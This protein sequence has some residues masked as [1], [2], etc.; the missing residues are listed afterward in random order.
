[1]RYIQPLPVEEL[2]PYADQIAGL[3][4]NALDH[5][6]DLLGSGWVQVK[7]GMSCRGLEGFR[8]ESGSPVVADQDGEWL[9]GRINRANEA[10][11]R[12][13]WQLIGPGYRPIDWQIDFKSGYRWS[14]AC[15]YL[16]IPYGHLPGVDIKV[17]WELAR[18]QHLPQLAWAYGLASAGEPGFGAP[19]VYAREFRSQVLDFIA[20]NPPRFGVN[21]AGAMDAA[22]RVTNW[23]ITY[24]LFRAYGAVFDEAFERELTRS[25]I[26]H[27][28]HLLSN[29]DWHAAWRGNHYLAEMAG[30]FVV[31]MYLSPEKRKNNFTAESAEKRN[32][33]TRNTKARHDAER[34]LALARRELDRETALQFHADGSNFEASTSYHRLAAEM[35]VYTAALALNLPPGKFPLGHSMRIEKMGEF[36]QHITKPSG[37]VPQ[38]GDND[39]GRFLKLFP[40]YER[41]TTE[42]ACARYAN[43]DGYESDEP[44]YWDEDVLDHRHLLAALNGLFGRDDWPTGPETLIVRGLAGGRQ[45]PSYRTDGALSAA[46]R[47]RIGGSWAD[48]QE[49]VRGLPYSH[50]CEDSCRG[51]ACCAQ[52]PLRL[53]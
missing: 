49:R 46:E 9:N 39:S 17:P 20:T 28:K 1:M 47:V 33:K 12:R 19:E 36:T 24:D 35:I 43:L 4:Q 21:W 22:I 10:E 34:W 7:H 8:Y 38:I 23:L 13:I 42:E 2:R 50:R 14:E 30:L 16:D 18:M 41:L 51:A 29:R 27:G 11:L 53:S 40:A 26:Q 32:A 3:A 45:M 31:G 15:W 52:Y 44:I 25:A 48:Q 5:R 6:F 37:R